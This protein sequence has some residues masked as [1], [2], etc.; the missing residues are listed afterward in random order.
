MPIKSSGQA[1]VDRA[2]AQ[3]KK[4]RA[5]ALKLQKAGLTMRQIGERLGVS[6]QRASEI[7]ARA[8]V[9]AEVATGAA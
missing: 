7:V 6:K 1:I 8:K 5:R 3:A 2:I 9:E 4:R